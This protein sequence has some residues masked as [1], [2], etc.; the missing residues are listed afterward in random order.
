M[1]DLDILYYMSMPI[2]IL[3]KEYKVVWDC[4]ISKAKVLYA[5]KGDRVSDWQE[6]SQI[7]DSELKAH[8]YILG[9]RSLAKTDDYDWRNYV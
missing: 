6:V 9:L 8:A 5:T 7:F 2:T 4:E 1:A 3:D